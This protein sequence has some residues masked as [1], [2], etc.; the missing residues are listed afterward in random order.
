MYV[1]MDH[2][3]DNLIEPVAYTPDVEEYNA[4]LE[5]GISNFKK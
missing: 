5:K 1:L 3:E 2:N 4:W